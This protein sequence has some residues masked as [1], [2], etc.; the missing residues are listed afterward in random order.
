M[1]NEVLNYGIR[2]SEDEIKY[3]KKNLSMRYPLN[4]NFKWIVIT[5]FGVEKV[6]LL[7]NMMVLVKLR[8]CYQMV[9]SVTRYCMVILVFF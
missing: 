2:F 4:M 1:I 5:V 6:F 9:K 7:G 3:K 8:L